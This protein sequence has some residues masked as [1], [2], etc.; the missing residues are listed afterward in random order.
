MVKNIKMGRISLPMD[1]KSSDAV[2]AFESMLTKGPMAVVLVYA[3]W[4]GHC[5]QYKKNVWSPLKSV[6]N[7]TINMASVRED[8]IKSTSLKDAKI[9][10]YPSILVVGKDKKPAVF[11]S[12]SGV[13]NALPESNDVSTMRSL[14]TAPVPNEVTAVPDESRNAYAVS[15]NSRKINTGVNISYP[16]LKASKQKNSLLTNSMASNNMASNSMASN[17]MASNSMASNS[18]ASN[19][20]PTNSMATDAENTYTTNFDR[21]D[22][23][24]V[25]NTQPPLI[26]EDELLL[27]PVASPRVTPVNNQGT[28]PIL[29]GGRLLRKLSM[30]RKAKKSSKR[31]S[32]KIV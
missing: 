26:N 7:R 22:T 32:K 5:D 23:P 2:P 12:T 15:N 20:M 24:T 3:D 11:K 19:S 1:V 9:D 28:T 21:S 10:G 29:R 30:K 6:K 14:I 18:M 31:K 13:T 4:C 17:S 27:S 16:S 8:M 25:R